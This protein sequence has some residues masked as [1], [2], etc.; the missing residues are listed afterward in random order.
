L[1]PPS[2][3]CLIALSVSSL[4]TDNMDKTTHAYFAIGIFWVQ[5]V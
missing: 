2:L 3:K 1:A 5:W 4:R